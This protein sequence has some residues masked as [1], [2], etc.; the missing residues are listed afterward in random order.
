MG[1]AMPSEPQFESKRR[2]WPVKELLLLACA[3]GVVYAA[4]LLRNESA[5]T[6]QAFAF[7]TL[8]NHVVSR[9]ELLDGHVGVQLRREGNQWLVDTLQTA[10]AL[11]P[12]NERVADTR[13]VEQLVG[14]LRSLRVGAV[15]TREAQEGRLF[16]FDHGAPRVALYDASQRE[17]AVVHIGKPGPEYFSRYIRIGRDVAVYVVPYD[18][19]AHM[20][21]QVAAWADLRIWDLD[22]DDIVR[23]SVD[24]R[25][26][27]FTLEKQENGR[28]LLRD[29]YLDTQLSVERIRPWLQALATLQANAHLTSDYERAEAWSTLQLEVA[30]GK[31]WEA[32]FQPGREG[33]VLARVSGGK[34]AYLVPTAYEDLLHMPWEDFVESSQ[35]LVAQ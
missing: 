32:R 5:A 16:G 6:E 21:M 26:Q 18:L 33:G 24:T 1:H 22:P 7:P 11:Q 35:Y 12:P 25:T 29:P 9:I 34:S 31:I 13:R 30:S 17:L 19:L 15:V 2:A 23:V 27:S 8:H 14:A 3:M 4:L 20:P 10:A 28:F